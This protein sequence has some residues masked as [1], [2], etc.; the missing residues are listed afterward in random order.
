[1]FE[2]KPPNNLWDY[3]ED[4][5]QANEEAFGL[6]SEDR[7]IYDMNIRFYPQYLIPLLATKEPID[8]LQRPIDIA[9]MFFALS[10]HMTYEGI[11]SVYKPILPRMLT[12]SGTDEPMFLRGLRRLLE[13]DFIRPHSKRINP[14]TNKTI[15][16][17]S[18][19]PFLATKGGWPQTFVRRLWWGGIEAVKEL[20]EKE[21]RDELD[22]YSFDE[23]EDIQNR[24]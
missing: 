22:G 8:P 20:A 14:Y 23:L 18:I 16:T 10:Y 17:Y 6:S 21:E 24:S 4:I 5:M 2:I 7:P 3:N 19:N 9:A 12:L 13:E 15:V 11:V 1:M